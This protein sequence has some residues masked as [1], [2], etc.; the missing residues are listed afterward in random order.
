V[1]NPA[2]NTWEQKGSAA[3]LR[4]GVGCG[5]INNKLYVIGGR[6][7]FGGP[8]GLV[9]NEVY[10]PSLDTWTPPGPTL[11]A[12]SGTSYVFADA[13]AKY[14]G[15]Y[16]LVI[17]QLTDVATQRYAQSIEGFGSVYALDFDWQITDIGG[18]GSQ[19]KPQGLIT[20][21]ETDPTGSLYFYNSSG[22]PVVRWFNGSGFNHLQNSTWNNWHKLTVVRNGVNSRVVFDE[23]QYQSP[24]ITSP[25]LTG[26]G[27]IKFGIYFATTQYL[28]NVR[29]RS[30]STIEPTTT[31]GGEVPNPLPVELNSFSALVIGSKVK[32]NWKTETEVSNYGFDVERKVGSRLSE[33]GNFEKIGFVEGNGNSNSPKYYSFED[34]N[35]TAGKYSYRLKQIDTD[36]QF[37]YSKVIEIN[38]DRPM[39]YELSQNYPN[40]FNPV[41]TIQFSI[42]EAGDVKLVVYNVLGEQVAEL[43]NENKEAGVHTINFNAAELNSGL[44]IYKLTAGNF[45]A[46]KKLMLV[47]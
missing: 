25:P 34:N 19:P 17:Q 9:Y 39:K 47:K 8:Y 36:G 31:V 28:D 22:T 37:E 23:N 44:Y 33:A 32:L 38:L 43:V 30:Y 20:L 26:T 15:N 13:S 5:V 14:Q 42:P 29:V 41:T 7:D 45:R 6:A 35:L 27:K 18:I 1:Y 3:H 11:W 10:D 4:D 21:T 16:G 2:T 40:P 24:S 12:T 46:V